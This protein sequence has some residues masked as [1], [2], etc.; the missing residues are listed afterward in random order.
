MSEPPSITKARESVRRFLE[1]GVCPTV[2][3]A[4]H[5]CVWT[6]RECNATMPRTHWYDTDT[7]EWV[8][9]YPRCAMLPPI[10]K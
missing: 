2:E 6:C 3:E 5:A 8:R 9:K 10:K 1:D 4:K 7:G